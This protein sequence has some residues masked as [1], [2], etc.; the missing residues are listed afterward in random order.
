MHRRIAFYTV[1]LGLLFCQP[2]RSQEH[3]QFGAYANY[4]RLSDFN[5]HNFAG[6]GGRFSGSASP[7]VQMEGELAYDFGQVFTET[8]EN[9]S[10][11]VI[12]FQRSPIRVLHGLFGPKFHTGEGPWRAFFVLK[13]GFIHFRFDE[14]PATFGTF[15]SSV[16][17]MR[18]D[19]T[20]P[21]LY[22]G[23]GLEGFWGP[24]GVRFEVGDEIFFLD[25]SRH[26]LRVSFGPV[27]RF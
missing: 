3:V 9:P 10:T 18:S 17:D 4:F 21:V 5:H 20:R 25:G 16:Q 12:A 27:L 6:L 23:G 26:N 1:L 8:F 24:L 19:N 22:P 11:G 14:R 7:H 13:S 2:I 15:T